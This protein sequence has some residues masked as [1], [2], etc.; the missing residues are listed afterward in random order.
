MLT[1]P[2]QNQPHQKKF[3]TIIVLNFDFIKTVEKLSFK[4][5]QCCPKSLN[6]DKN[7]P[8]LQKYFV[9]FK[10]S[11]F[12]CHPSDKNQIPKYDFKKLFLFLIYL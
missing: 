2:P 6:P 3:K 1:L 7:S 5:S 8:A 12:C 9:N 11:K 4:R 10:K